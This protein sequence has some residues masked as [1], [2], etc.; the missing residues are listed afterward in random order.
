VH[1]GRASDPIVGGV[2]HH[3][4]AGNLT[5]EEQS[6]LLFLFIFLFYSF[7]FEENYFNIFNC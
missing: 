4:V 3:V 1:P 7:I 6:V 5:L 2:S